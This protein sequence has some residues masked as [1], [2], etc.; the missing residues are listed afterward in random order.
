ML[1]S[2]HAK[3]E[4]KEELSKK[5]KEVEAI[6]RCLD[7]WLNRHRDLVTTRYGKLV[8]VLQGERQLAILY[9]E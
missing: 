2:E 3:K 1:Q 8:K 6:L 7:L 4:L 9:D 5:I